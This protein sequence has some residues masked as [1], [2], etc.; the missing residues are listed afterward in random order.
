[1]QG[2]S[3][4]TSIKTRKWYPQWVLHLTLLASLFLVCDCGDFTLWDD[5]DSDGTIEAV[6]VVSDEEPA[7]C[8]TEEVTLDGTESSGEDLIFSWSLIVPENSE[9]Y[10]EDD[11]A[12]ETSFTPDKPG[13][14]YVVLAVWDEDDNTDSVT[15]TVVAD[16]TPIADADADSSTVCVGEEVVF[17]G[18]GSKDPSPTDDDYE[19]SYEEL[20]FSWELTSMPEES[21]SVLD[22]SDSVYPTLT[23]DVA[24]TYTATLTV[25]RDGDG[26]S[27]EDVVSVTAEECE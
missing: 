23:P 10:I 16:D 18:S 9:S 27:S 13:T 21:I 1:M 22:E 25:T 17:D 24:G 5:E 12:D 11:D 14:Y 6:I 7:A 26:A 19:C 3:L 4:R 8:D 2:F 20:S 15:I